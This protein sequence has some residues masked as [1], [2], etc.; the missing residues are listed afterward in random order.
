MELVSIGSAAG[1]FLARQNIAWID[2]VFERSIYISN[3]ADFLCLGG[4]DLGHGPLIATLKSSP[5]AGWTVGI[6]PGS[7]VGLRADRMSVANLVV[8]CSRAAAWTPPLPP[9]SSPDP[10]GITGIL[11]RLPRMRASRHARAS[12]WPEAGLA[13]AVLARDFRDPVSAAARAPLHA[14]SQAIA[15]ALSGDNPALTRAAAE[16]APLFGLGP[17][18]TPSGDD[19]FAGTLIALCSLYLE[20]VAQRLWQ[21]L[22]PLAATRTSAL[23]LAHL[24]AAATGQ[25][26]Q[27]LHLAIYTLLSGKEEDLAGSLTNL[28]RLGHSSGF[29]GFAGAILAIQGWI[30]LRAP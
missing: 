5:P 25:G 7:P 15:A 16:A 6:R 19:V 29:D 24:R 12:L 4:P 27:C 22:A 9:P 8:D 14:L 23:S 10:S 28:A 3:G 18:L 20:E 26:H 17:G 30:A 13:R 1:A 2:A 21:V 11:L